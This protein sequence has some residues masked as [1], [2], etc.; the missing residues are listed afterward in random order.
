MS[1]IVITAAIAVAASVPL[2]LAAA[3]VGKAASTRVS[4]NLVAGL[5]A[6]NDLRRLVLARP[7]RERAVQPFL[8]LLA[9]RVRRVTPRGIVQA[10]ERRLPMAGVPWALESVLAAKVGLAAL[11]TGTSLAWVAAV[12][13]PAGAL[14]VPVAGIAGWLAPD[15]VIAH[16]AGA[17]QRQ[18]LDDLPD[19]LDQLTICVE[20]GLA[21]DAALVRVARS[22]HGPLGDEM[23]RVLQDV[24]IGIPRTEAFHALLERTDVAEL[25]QFVHAMSQA[26]SY[27]VPVASVLRT[28]SAEQRQ[29]RCGRAEERAQKLPVKLVFPLVLCI[30]PALFVV[31]L[32]PAALRV[33]RIF[34]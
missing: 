24:Q 34:G 2:A 15:A 28:Q 6:P 19:T 30:L 29:K 27:G 22:G 12:P 9:G 26:E 23:R 20:A 16:R 7:A 1:P 18:I 32:G 3:F 11:A 25:R 13:S 8:A 33:A 4:H 14:L 10:L 17:R 21:F 5:S 31:V